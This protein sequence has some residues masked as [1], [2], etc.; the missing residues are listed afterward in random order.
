M[1]IDEIKYYVLLIEN[2]LNEIRSDV[3]WK[4]SRAGKNNIL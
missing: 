3:R 2:F 1:I 4:I